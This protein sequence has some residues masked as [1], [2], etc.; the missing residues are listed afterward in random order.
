MRSKFFNKRIAK[1]RDSIDKRRGEIKYLQKKL[2]K[3]LVDGAK[4]YKEAVDKERMM[5]AE[6]AR[7]KN[8]R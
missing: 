6:K 8:S 1:L 2:K 3:K 5:V 7:L 4:K